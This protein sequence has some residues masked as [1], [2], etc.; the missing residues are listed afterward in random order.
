MNGAIQALSCELINNL[1]NQ[2]K[3][4]LSTLG[5][6]FFIYFKELFPIECNVEQWLKGLDLSHSQGALHVVILIKIKIN[7]LIIHIEDHFKLILG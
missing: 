1:I 3:V 6:V 7:H 4:S 5:M 2:I